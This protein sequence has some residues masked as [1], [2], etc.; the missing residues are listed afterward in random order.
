M[1]PA[2]LR[3]PAGACDCHMHVYEDR[4]ALAPTATFKPPHAPDSEYHKVQAALGL[5]HA[6]EHG[7]VHRDIKPSNISCA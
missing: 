3:T 2:A 1:K 5:Q 7:L 4:F 6:H